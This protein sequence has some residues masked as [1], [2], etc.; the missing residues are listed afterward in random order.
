[1][2]GP[3]PGAGL[4]S[5]SGRPLRVVGC[6]PGT[7]SLDLLL[8]ADGGVAG[9]ARIEPE[10][11]SADRLLAQLAAWGPLDLIAG[12]SGYGVPLRR[13]DELTEADVEAM[14]LVRPDE[15][16]HS[17]GVGGFRSWVRALAA[18]GLPVIALWAAEDAAVPLRAVGSLALWNRQAKHEVIEGAGHDLLST[19]ADRVAGTLRDVLR[20]D[21][22]A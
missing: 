16:G 9:G 8:L 21:F 10:P 2:P 14:S 11:G 22:P 7:S 4:L 3:R 6:D 5:G 20:E 19:H 15:R 13:T 1:M 12:P 18:S 17:V